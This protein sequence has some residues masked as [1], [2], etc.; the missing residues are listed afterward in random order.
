MQLETI[1]NY[2]NIKQMV[3]EVGIS[4]SNEKKLK[5]IK[6]FNNFIYALDYNNS[7]LRRGIDNKKLGDT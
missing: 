2:L 1:I 6:I 7:I 5:Q 3:Q 4:V